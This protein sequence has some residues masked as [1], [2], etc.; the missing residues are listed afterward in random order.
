MLLACVALAT[1]AQTLTGFAFGLIFLSLAATLDLATVPDAA[2]VATVLSLVNAGTYLR[3]RREPLPWGLM[4][5]A[6]ISS[7]VLV[8][9]GLALLHWLSGAAAQWL[10]G[11]LGVSIIACAAALML[12][13]HLRTEVAPPRVFAGVG[14]ISGLLGGLFGT[15]GP[16]IVFL[17][18]RQ[19]LPADLIRRCLLL[20]FASNAL[21][22][23]CVVLPGGGFS[24]RSVV[25]AVLALPVVHFFTGQGLR[26]QPK[27]PV[28]VMRWAV[29]MLLM[30]TGASLVVTALRGMIPDPAAATASYEV[31]GTRFIIPSAH[32]STWPH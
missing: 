15:S 23:L 4:R 16:P 24:L 3:A 19:P 26:L 9:V 5:P 28:Q 27:V 2:N 22:R 12:R 21:I 7:A 20:M 13:G 14:A 6:L 10:R 31:Q 8:V 25:L 17:L 32:E 29:A 11:L 30:G 18:Y 1:V